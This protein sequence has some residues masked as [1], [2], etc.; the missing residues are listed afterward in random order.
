MQHA[1]PSLPIL[2]AERNGMKCPKCRCEN[3]QDACSCNECPS[4]L[5]IAY[6]AWGKANLPGGKFFKGCGHDLPNAFEALPIETSQPQS[7][8]LKYLAELAP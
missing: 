1:G 3:Q 4:K 7:Y 8:T 6:P 2:P 5:E